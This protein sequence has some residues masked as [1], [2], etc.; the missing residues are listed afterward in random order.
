MAK[1]KL[2]PHGTE[3]HRKGIDANARRLAHQK[4]RAELLA[5]RVEQRE[6]RR[7]ERAATRRGG[8]GGTKSSKSKG[9]S[10]SSVLGK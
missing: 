9:G 4:E 5:K 2:H 3:A 10:L 7:G 1:Q 8:R 6:K